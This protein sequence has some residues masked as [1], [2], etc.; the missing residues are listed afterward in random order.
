MPVHLFGQPAAMDRITE[1]ATRH[2]L[3]VLED[4]AQAIGARTPSGR[5]GALGTAAS[6]SF[7]PSKNVGGFGDGGLVT[8]NDDALAAR[9]RLMRHHGM[10]PK[11]FHQVVGGNFR[12][13]ALQAAL[14]RVKLPF[15]DAW[16]EARRAN[17]RAYTAAFGAAGLSTSKLIAPSEVEPGHVWN[18]YVIRTPRRDALRAHLASKGNATE[19]YYPLALHLQPALASLGYA[20]GSMPESERATREVLALPVFPELGSARVAR[21]ASEV[22]LFLR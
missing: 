17:A 20:E 9:M 8:T 13:D 21:V 2:G 22:A 15:V 16:S 12:I 3:R 6:F 7:F 11:Y 19:V 10:S 1:I 18:Q 5:V 14:L 4:A